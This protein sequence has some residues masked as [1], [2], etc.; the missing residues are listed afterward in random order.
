MPPQ[1]DPPQQVATLVRRRDHPQVCASRQTGAVFLNYQCLMNLSWIFLGH[2]SS[3]ARKPTNLLHCSVNERNYPCSSQHSMFLR[4][5]HGVVQRSQRPRSREGRRPVS[6][7]HLRSRASNGDLFPEIKAQ[8]R[9]EL[10]AEYLEASWRGD[11]A[12]QL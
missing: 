11:S 4:L 9:N 3:D 2:Q 12:A 5:A 8:P 1:P 7:A 10:S 6:R